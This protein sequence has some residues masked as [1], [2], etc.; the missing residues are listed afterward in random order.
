MS[1]QKVGPGEENSPATSA[2]H[3]DHESDALTTELF[4]HP[5]PNHQNSNRAQ[6]MLIIV[7][8][9]MIQDKLIIV[10]LIMV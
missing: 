1:A 8:L 5:N 3:F 7:I 4:P 2:G 10:I 9:I 6:N